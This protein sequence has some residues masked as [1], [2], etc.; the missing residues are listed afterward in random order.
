MAC[1]DSTRGRDGF[2][3]AM[4]G[5]SDTGDLML[6]RLWQ[7]IRSAFR[8]TPSLLNDHRRRYAPKRCLVVDDSAANQALLRVVLTRAGHVV[9]TVSDGAAALR[10]MGAEAFDVVFLD[11]HMPIMSGFEVLRRLA[12]SHPPIIVVSSESDPTRISDV[13]HAGA[14]AYVPKPFSIPALLDSLTQAIEAR[15]ATGTAPAN[16]NAEPCTL[17]EMRQWDEPASIGV[18]LAHVRAE[19]LDGMASAERLF[20]NGDHA[21]AADCLHAIKNNVAS[22]GD[23]KAAAQCK[24]LEDALR[25]GKTTDAALAALRSTIDATAHWIRQQPEFSDGV[26]ALPKRRRPNR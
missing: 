3:E 13:M 9:S 11:L 16:P 25:S 22:I 5:L 2:R 26:V 23:S 19:L 17:S 4:A 20:S 24:A 10:V 14:I 7:A 21:G 6:R 12:P 18:F 8:S 1:F 15:S